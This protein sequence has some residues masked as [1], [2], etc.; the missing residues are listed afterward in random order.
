M[1]VQQ[2]EGDVVG[3][4][5]QREQL[6]VCRVVRVQLARQVGDG[7]ACAIWGFRGQRMGITA[8]VMPNPAPFGVQ[9]ISTWESELA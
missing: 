4:R 2:A 7:E 1:L 9:G 3:G 6:P 5:Q 8:E